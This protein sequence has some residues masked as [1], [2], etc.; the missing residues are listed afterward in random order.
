MP[1][2]KVVQHMCRKGMTTHNVLAVCDFDVRFTL[3]LTG[4]P[5]SVHDMRVFTDA[6]TKYGDM[7]PHPSTGK[8]L[9]MLQLQLLVQLVETYKTVL[10]CRKFF[11]LVDSGYS[12]C[13]GYLT[14]YKET[15]YHLLEY[16]EGPEPKGKKE[17]FNFA[18]SSLRN[19]I[20]RS[21]GVLKMK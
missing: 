7:F 21:F 19:V 12:N 10:L 3:V 4:W 16:R 1:S 18:H 6:M 5:G 14:P 13:P 20:E 8:Y 9:P 15:K 17:I 2:D 11:Y